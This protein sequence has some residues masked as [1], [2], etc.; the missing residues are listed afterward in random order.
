MKRTINTALVVLGV[1][2]CLPAAAALLVE[3]RSTTDGTGEDYTSYLDGQRM[4]IGGADEQQYVLLDWDRKAMYTVDVA[5]KGALDMSASFKEGTLG[6]KCPEP[7]VEAVLERVGAGPRIAGYATDHY[8]LKADGKACMEVFASRKALA[9]MDE[10]LDVV[11]K[12]MGLDDHDV[13]RSRCEIAEDKALDPRQIGWPLKTIS[14]S[15][16]EKGTVEEVLRI[17]RVSVDAAFFMIPAG[18]EVVTF[19]QMHPGLT[20]AGG[21]G[22]MPQLPCPSLDEYDELDFDEEDAED[23]YLEEEE[24][25]GEAGYEGAP[26]RHSEGLDDTAREALDEAAKDTVKDTV[27]GLFNGLKKGFGG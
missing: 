26:P 7:S 12:T 1:G 3:Q 11:E 10:W 17:E 14:L 5:A 23:G 20:G 19:D 25:Y 9:A 24:P 13:G 4:R 15:G 6:R 16:P 8:V 27:K 22:S 18:F 21:S 2:I